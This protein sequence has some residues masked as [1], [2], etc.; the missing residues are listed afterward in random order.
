MSAGHDKVSV[1]VLKD[2]AGILCK[3][4]AAIFNSSFE[5]GTF[6]D[7]RKMA[8]VTSIFKSALKNNMN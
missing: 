3:P 6:P 5:M 7:I 2:A 8:R 1:K 4:L